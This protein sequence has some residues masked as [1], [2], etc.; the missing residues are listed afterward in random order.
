LKP[1]GDRPAAADAG[2]TKGLHDGLDHQ[3][4]LGVTGSGKTPRWLA[5]WLDDQ[6]R[7]LF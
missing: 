6:N 4:L 5:L 1:G 3:T 2:C 7:R